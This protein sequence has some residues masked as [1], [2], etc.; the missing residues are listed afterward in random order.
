MDAETEEIV[1][2]VRTV[3]KEFADEAEEVIAQWIEISKPLVAKKK[4][5]SLYNLAL[6]LLVCHKMK[7]SGLGDETIGN[8]DDALRIGSY[9]EGSVSVSFSGT[10]SGASQTDGEYGLTIYGIQYLQIRRMVIVPIT[11]D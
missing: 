5:K 11:I 7:L 4:F 2:T 10:M 3:G 6:A 8:L 9:S 1:N